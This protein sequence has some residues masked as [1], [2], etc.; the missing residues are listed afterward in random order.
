MPFGESIGAFPEF[1]AQSAALRPYIWT[2]LG[3]GGVAAVAAAV[4]NWKETIR[5]K[6]GRLFGFGAILTGVAIYSAAA[7][8]RHYVHYL[9]FLAVPVFAWSAAGLTCFDAQV[10]KRK[11]AARTLITI[12]VGAVWATF[13]IVP[14]TLQEP[15]GE[16]PAGYLEKMLAAPP[17]PVGAAVRKYGKPGEPLAVWGWMGHLFVETGMWRA[18]RDSV[19]DYA[20]IGTGRPGSM[21]VIE[22]Y[23]NAV[24][25]YFQDLFMSDLE[26]S[27]P[28]VF[29]DAVSPLGGAFHNR[30]LFGY[31]TF[32]PLAAYVSAH[33]RFVEE[34]EGVRIFLRTDT[35]PTGG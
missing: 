22:D 24:P 16:Y 3:L 27:Q 11:V 35:R 7:P 32:P 21:D 4:M 13:A 9:L 2:A 8:G 34:V 1:F 10:Q 12:I 14:Q 19:L 17:T 23:K 31:E 25:R 5:S 15:V 29:V 20:W 6:G 30:A 33:Y 18:T 28:A 26:K